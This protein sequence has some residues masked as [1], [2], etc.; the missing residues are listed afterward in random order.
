MEAKGTGCE[1]YLRVRRPVNIHACVSR[2][3]TSR[4]I[5]RASGTYHIIHM[6]AFERNVHKVTR[7]LIF[8]QLIFD[9]ITILHAADYFTCSRLVFMRVI[10]K[11]YGC[12]TLAELLE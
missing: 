10:T 11:V 5:P 7:Q 9:Q 4:T 8:I 1:Q 3:V 12:W 2:N 6:Y